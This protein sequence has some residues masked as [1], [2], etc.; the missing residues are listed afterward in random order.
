LNSDWLIEPLPHHPPIGFFAYASAPPSIPETIRAA[1]QGINRSQ[2]AQIRSWEDL[3]V[4]GKIIIGEVCSAIDT[5]DF[6]CADVTTINPN[7]MFELGYA[8]AQNKRIWLVRDESYTDSR[9]EF[10][11]LKVL[12]T[13]GYAVY[14]NSAQIIKAFFTEKPHTTQD[15]TIFRLSVEPL[16][17]PAPPE[18]E[19]LLYLKSRF[20]TEASVRITRVLQDIRLPLTVD[21]PRETSVRPL[22]WYCQKLY[23]AMAFAAHFLSA[24]R[25]GHRLHNARYAFVS[26]LARGF[27]V[28]SLMLTEQDDLL[29][30]LDYRDAIRVYATPSEAARIATDWI[31]P[32]AAQR[33]PQTIKPKP[34][35]DVVRLATELKDFH[36]QLG[37]YVAENEADRLS[38]YFVETTAYSDVINGTHTIFVGRKGTGKT[39]N[40]IRAADQIGGDVQNLVV[41]IKPPG[42]EIEGLA[43]LFA[44]YKEQDQK[45]YVIESLWKY[46]LYSEIAHTLSHQMQEAALWQLADPSAQEVVALLEAPNSPFAGDFTVR[47]ERAVGALSK[48]HS[49]VVEPVETFRRGISEALHAGA[50]GQLRTKLTD[51]LARKH[52]VLLLI[53]NLDKPWTK[54]ADLEQ[55]AEFL[56]GLLGAANRVAEEIRQKFKQKRSVRFNSA[57]FL[58]S[59]IFNR[60][61]GVAREPDKLSFTRLRWDDP[62]L[63]LR[64]V[65]ERYVVSHGTASDPAEMWHRYFG[66]QVRGIPMRDYLVTR[67]LPRPRDIVFFVKAA[68]SFAVNRKHDRVEERDVLDGERQYSQYALDSILVENGISIPELEAVLLEFVGSPPIVSESVARR[69]VSRSGIDPEK[70]DSVIAHLVN[71]TFLGLE[72]SKGRF[73]YSDDPKEVKKNRVLAE[74][75]R[76]D[77]LVEQ[78]YEI[79]PPF[80]VYL[81][82]DETPRSQYAEQ[83]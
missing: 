77:Y 49:A 62:E 12:T 18:G 45:G 16:L 35:A 23:G 67:I 78:R 29:A 41:L 19:T 39:T 2:A 72:V 65:E 26:G 5:A 33:T 14:E 83:T 32:L 63:L 20:D 30:P 3:D 31:Q 42:Y 74:H 48:V 54:S 51:V 40:L 22:T 61:V 50:L 76:R 13:V 70:V 38:A 64:V 57:V 56:L 11:Q 69:H 81:E 37:E 52:Q 15:E 73:E 47:L 4:G 75:Y 17:V 79:N 36:L 60:V 21:D 53:D 44:S 58:R 80:R 82:I 43:R 27:E 6:F 46:M 59:D 66:H 24:A 28:K 71:L 25:E 55:L 8:V 1:I 9:K 34:Y 7:V 10:E 68:V